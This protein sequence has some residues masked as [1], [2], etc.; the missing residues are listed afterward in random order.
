MVA[1][2]CGGGCGP[3]VV[4]PALTVEPGPDHEFEVLC[5]DRGAF[6]RRYTVDGG[7]VTTVDTELDGVTGYSPSGEVRTCTDG[8]SDDESLPEP[9]CRNTTSVLLCDLADETGGQEP[10]AVDSDIEIA[11]W[12]GWV[13]L[14]GGGQAL[15]DGGSLQ[16]PSEPN[17][18]AGNGRETHRWVS[19]QLLAPVGACNMGD[20]ATVTVHLEAT[21]DGPANACGAFGSARIMHRDGTVY[22]TTGQGLGRAQD[23]AY[24]VGRT[25]GVDL[26]ATVPA[27]ELAAGNVYV[28]LNLR[29]YRQS[30][31]DWDNCFSAAEGPIGWTVSGFTWEVELP[32]C[33]SQFLRHVTVDC[34][35]NVLSTTDTTLDGAPYT[36]TGEVGQCQATSRPDPCGDTELV[37]LCDHGNGDQ[38]FLRRFVF[39]CDGAVTGTDDLTLDGQTYEPVGPVGSCPTT[40]SG[41]ESPGEP[42]QVGG[43]QTVVLCDAEGVSFVRTYQLT[44]DGQITGFADSTLDGASFVPV[45]PVGVC[46][47]SS[48]ESLP[49]PCHDTELLTLCDWLD[50]PENTVV[51]FLRHV[52][53]DCTGAV[54]ATADTELDATT[55]YTPQG[56]VKACE[57]DPETCGLPADAVTSGEANSG[58]P[59]ELQVVDV[60]PPP[61]LQYRGQPTGK[62]TH[63]PLPGGGQTLWDG[64]TLVFPADTEGAGGGELHYVNRVI[65]A[66]LI[67]ARPTCDDGTAQITVQVHAQLDGPNPG[68]GKYYGGLRLYNSRT[69]EYFAYDPVAVEGAKPQPGYAHTMSL[70]SQVL[71]QDLANGNILV[72]LALETYETPAP[73]RD[74]A[75]GPKQWTTSDFQASYSYGT[76]G[77]SE[78][79]PTLNVRLCEPITIRQEPQAEDLSVTTRTV[80]ERRACDD[81]DGDGQPDVTYSELWEVGGNQPPTLIGTYTTADLAQEYDPQNPVPCLEPEPITC[82]MPP[83]DVTSGSANSGEPGELQVVDNTGAIYR[84]CSHPPLAGGGQVLWDGGNLQFGPDL[85]GSELCETPDAGTYRQVTAQLIAARP[86]CD[87]G[88]AEVTVSVD[89]ELQGTNPAAYDYIG[90]LRLYSLRTETWFAEDRLD[91]DHPTMPGFQ[92]TLTVSATVAAEDLA[93]GD[94]VVMLALET[95]EDIPRG[96]GQQGPTQWLASNFRASYSYNTEGCVDELPLMAVKICEPIT[97]RYQ[98]EPAGG[99]PLPTTGGL[100][101]VQRWDDTDNDGRPDTPYTE[102]WQ[103]VPG[104]SPRLVDTYRSQPGDGY[105]PT[106]PVDPEPPS[107]VVATGGQR[108][109]PDGGQEVV[110]VAGSVGRLLSATVTVITGE[111]T[112]T[113]DSGSLPIP[114]GASLTWG[115]S[116]PG[117]QLSTLVVTVPDG[118]DALVH[119]THQ[120][121]AGQVVS[122]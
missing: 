57:P 59:G 9:E 107:P 83:D 82:G 6:L 105:L 22:R 41:E 46:P 115:T 89:V 23:P 95:W 91:A 68:V 2:K 108:I 74:P 29:T 4:R 16:F 96:S 85:Q 64:G 99:A 103:M 47:A 34:D 45:E 62:A 37:T 58:A 75:D 81:T 102:V 65:A 12:P 84:N 33:E 31:N 72:W 42:P 88:T 27:A 118:G 32:E 119:Y 19:A 38:L 40:S 97:T 60:Q 56:E 116:D 111:A 18:N 112:V 11:Q 8:D 69:G 17:G 71:A 54:T 66:Q 36:V 14:P 30:L 63:E 79:G 77:C 53:Y 61:L 98:I 78:E 114:A 28:W 44:A 5:D 3:I 117:Q 80:I 92:Q 86:T 13:P 109:Q 101:P 35:G 15:W 48:E 26:T 100:V 50:D 104:Q 10:A 94:I 70:T 7:V 55:P 122:A 76:E 113:T 24:L 121:Q 87:D 1:G 52:T 25:I 90:G 49:E 106:N 21:V 39:G 93:S 43:P 73:D 110:D 67:A 51:R 20:T 120:G